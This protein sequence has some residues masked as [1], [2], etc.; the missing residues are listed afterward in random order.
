MNVQAS[1]NFAQTLVALLE[2]VESEKPSIAI[3]GYTDVMLNQSEWL[4]LNIDQEKLVNRPNAQHLTRIHGRDDV[5]VVPTL[6]SAINALTEREYTLT[7]FDFTK[8]EGSEEEADFNLPIPKKFHRKFDLVIDA[9]TCE[10]IFN[11]AQ[12]FSNI[13]QM[14]KVGGVAF[15]GGPLCWPNHGFYG[16]NPTLFCDFYEAN[17]CN[18]LELYLYTDIKQTHSIRVTINNVPKY[19]R[20]TMAGALGGHPDMLKL[21][22]NL[23]CVAKKEQDTPSVVFPIQNKYLNKQSWK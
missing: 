6:T 1:T 19:E 3:L 12:A 16:Y 22:Y 23:V 13:L 14:L 4:E 10:H 11:I 21:E 2:K 18:I 20:F 9:G 17:G 5:V 15:H 7:V 8:Y